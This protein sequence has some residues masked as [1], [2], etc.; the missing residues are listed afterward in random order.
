MVPP[1]SSTT[2]FSFVELFW[3]LKEYTVVLETFID[4]GYASRPLWNPINHL[5]PVHRET[6][7]L[8]VPSI[9]YY[10]PL[11]CQSGPEPDAACRAAR[12]QL[13][14][15][16]LELSSS[17]FNSKKNTRTPENGH[18]ESLTLATT[19][20]LSISYYKSI[21]NVTFVSLYIQP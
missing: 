5:F 19:T 20:L 15:D 10:S 4:R 12:C 8:L 14:I 6:L 3:K 9:W 17:I 16:Q 13:N 11:L 18:D 1:T 21:R 7:S 2:F